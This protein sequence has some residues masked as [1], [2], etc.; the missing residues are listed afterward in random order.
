MSILKLLIIFI[1]VMVLMAKKQPIYVAVS[2]GAG[3]TWILYG[4]T[5]A[6]GIALIVETCTAWNTLQLILIMYMITFLQKMM[7]HRGAIMKA[8]AGLSSLFNNRWINCAAAPIFI[9]ML[10]TPNSAFISG[11]IVKASASD[12]LE[13][14]EIAAA[15]TYFRHVPESF[16]PT[17]NSTILA[18]SLAG[19]TARAF[20]VGMLPVVAC[21]IA[22]GCFWFLRGK[23]PMT[24]GEAESS[25]KGKDLQDIVL[26]LWPILSVILMAVAF[27]M[28]IYTA[29]AI[30]VVLYSLISKFSATE[31]RP[32]FRAA[33]QPKLYLNTFSVMILK[34]F[35]TASGA[36]HALPDFFA[37][38]GICADILLR[39]HHIRFPGNYCPVSACC[40][41]IRP[42]CRTASVLSSDGHH[43]CGQPDVTNPCLPDADC[44]ILR[45][46]PGQADSEN[47]A[48]SYDNCCIYCDLLPGV[49]STP[50]LTMQKQP[51][52]NFPPGL[53]LFYSVIWLQAAS[54]QRC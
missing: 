47:P 35:L 25:N 44:G 11:D 36:I 21:I 34:E 30:I 14:D 39:H 2:A 4:I 51:R 33:L 26:G 43:L 45:H 52:Q 8:Q 23:V 53:K 7:E 50:C 19:V 28:N 54:C 41:G 24:A 10:P 13:Q 27:K 18:I 37:R 29:A 15:T 5:P 48:C 12:Y 20:V 6:D 16:M 38:H 42:Q 40:H 22:A 17:Y 31:L 1:F 49:D 32:F 3:V 9:G 46:I